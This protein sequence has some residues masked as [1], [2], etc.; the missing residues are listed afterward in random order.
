MGE[1]KRG[2]LTVREL[3]AELLNHDMDLPVLFYTP[4]EEPDPSEE[5]V[6]ISDENTDAI[7]HVDSNNEGVVLSCMAVELIGR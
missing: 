5:G 3:I 6:V 4:A 2:A 7:T 1:N